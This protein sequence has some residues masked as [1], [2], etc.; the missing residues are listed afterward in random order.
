MKNR[1]LAA[2]LAFV[3][4]TFGVHRFYLKDPGAGIF[5]L[6]LFF[7]TSRLFFPI[8]TILGFVDGFR[9]L[10]MSDEAFDRRYNEN[11]GQRKQY[12][13][14]RSQRRDRRREE[15]IRREGQRRERPTART[16]KPRTN[17]FKKSGIKKYKEFDLEDAIIDFNKGLE[18]DPTDVAL[19]FNIAC[20]YSLTEQKEKAFFHLAKAVELGFN[21]FEKIKTH[22]DL[23]FVRIQPEFEK[24][25][26]NDYRL[27]GNSS[28][29]TEQKT[30]RS[31]PIT[32][33]KLLSQLNKLAELRRKGLLSDEEFNLERKKLMRR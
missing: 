23:A 6:I 20:A 16:R 9:Y 32:D 27:S 11:Q 8:S 28:K 10:M 22:D 30:E 7:M 2:I 24:F 4:G 19:H 5:Y 3:F 1:V 29:K 14:R 13:S 17:P 26:E 25:Q 12:R 21:D 15:A 31:E 18:I 33:D